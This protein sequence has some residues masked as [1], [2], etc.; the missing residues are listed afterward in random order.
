MKKNNRL[1][2]FIIC[3]YGESPYLEDCVVSLLNQKEKCF[4]AISTSTPNKLVKKI[5]K[6]YDVPLYINDKNNGYCD[7]FMFAF[8]KA[9]TDY[10]TLAHQD[11]IYLEDFSKEMIKKI[12]KHQK[13]LILFS[14]YYD[15]KKDTIIK[16]S[17]LL[18]VK[19][20]LNFLLRFPVFQ[21]SK[22][23]RKRILS[24]GNP[25]CS[26]TVTFNKSLI[27]KPVYDCPFDTSYDWY[28]WINYVKKDGRFVYIN[29]PLLL[30]RINEE[31]ETTKMIGNNLKKNADYQIFKLFWPDFI[32]RKMVKIYSI[33]EKNNDLD[34]KN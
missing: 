3:A 11:D 30:R 23:I 28:T 13:I 12:K 20:F 26:P 17:K 8:N 25:I 4:V 34:I 6:K 15:Y 5:A 16:N 2:S 22:I 29:K 7:D 24:L 14:N 18:F 9:T 10:V 21:K 19:R 27:D 33:S 32:A 31:S 1:L